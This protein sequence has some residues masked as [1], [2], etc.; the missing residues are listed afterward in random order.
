MNESSMK[1][2]ESGDI[3]SNMRES[4]DFNRSA[5]QTKEKESDGGFRRGFDDNSELQTPD[6]PALM[7][8][9]SKIVYVAME[10]LEP[11]KNPEK[12]FRKS[13]GKNLGIHSQDWAEQFEACNIIR[14]VCKHHQ[15]LI[16]QAGYQLQSIAS[17]MIKLA[18]SLRSAVTRIALM[19]LNEMFLSLKRVMEPL[20][21][22][23]LK[24]LLKKSTDTNHF[25]AHEADKCMQSLVL[26]C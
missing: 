8:Q 13:T 19:T 7:T 14:R 21:D 5:S 6:D 24:I 26:N 4:T 9:S 18:E 20:L 12:E 16:L 10:D 11:L 22:P 25:I 17:I 1:R 15:T 23:V 2:N 3:D